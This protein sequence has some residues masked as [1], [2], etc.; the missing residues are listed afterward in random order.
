M[1]KGEGE[2]EGEVYGGGKCTTQY[3]YKVVIPG[4]SGWPDHLSWSMTSPS[5]D[6]G[7]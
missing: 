5:A 1:G 2:R 4:S 3:T 7:R 6:I